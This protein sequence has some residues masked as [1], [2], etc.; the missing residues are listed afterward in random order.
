MKPKRIAEVDVF[1][2][3]ETDRSALA[4]AFVMMGSSRG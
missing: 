2:Y 3:G 1:T 4:L